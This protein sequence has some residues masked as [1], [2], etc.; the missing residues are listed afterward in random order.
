MILFPV[1]V[2]VGMWWHGLQGHF[3]LF[4]LGYHGGP[5]YFRAGLLLTEDIYYW[6]LLFF[7]AR[8]VYHKIFKEIGIN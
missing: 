3:Q 7:P 6:L 5:V 1:R 2:R 4:F 8:E